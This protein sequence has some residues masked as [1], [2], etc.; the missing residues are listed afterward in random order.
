M[1]D[2]YLGVWGCCGAHARALLVARGDTSRYRGLYKLVFNLLDSTNMG[3]HSQQPC[4]PS[5]HLN[6]TVYI[7]APFRQNLKPDLIVKAL[8]LHPCGSSKIYIPPEKTAFRSSI[9]NPINDS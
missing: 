7:V 2:G 3:T 5:A 8:D 4:I 1:A 6:F 9:T